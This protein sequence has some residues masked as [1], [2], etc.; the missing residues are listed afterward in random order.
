MLHY[1]LYK[2]QT[3]SCIGIGISHVYLNNQIQLG[4]LFPY[5]LLGL[6]AC[7]VVRLG[8]VKDAIKAKEAKL[9]APE[10]G[11]PAFL[12]LDTVFNY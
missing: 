10:S 4:V 1:I 5:P 2:L 6:Y 11:N 3:F 7:K 12:S 8:H 9:Q